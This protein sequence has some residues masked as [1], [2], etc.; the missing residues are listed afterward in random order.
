MVGC[1]CGGLRLRAPH[2]GSCCWRET[3]DPHRRHR[4]SSSSEPITKR[5]RIVTIIERLTFGLI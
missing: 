1:D 2:M 3:I 5:Q 4:D